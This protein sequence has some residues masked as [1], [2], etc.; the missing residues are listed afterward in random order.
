MALISDC[1]VTGLSRATSLIQLIEFGKSFIMVVIGRL[2]VV[3]V[4]LEGLLP[5]GGLKHSLV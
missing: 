3:L 2:R 5:P 4:W 1:R